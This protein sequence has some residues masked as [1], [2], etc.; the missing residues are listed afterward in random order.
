MSTA[1]KNK[2]ARQP[3]FVTTG[4]GAPIAITFGMTLLT[5]GLAF[6]LSKMTAG[7]SYVLRELSLFMDGLAGNMWLCVP[8]LLC[9]GGAKLLVSA[10]HRVSARH[11]FLVLCILLLL[12][13]GYTLI[14]KVPMDGS[15]VSYMDYLAR[16]RD[17]RDPYADNPYYVY[18]QQAFRLGR[19]GAGGLL[20]M[21][22]A[23]PVWKL[24]RNVLGTVLLTILLIVLLMALFRFN[25]GRLMQSASAKKIKRPNEKKPAVPVAASVMNEGTAFPAAEPVQPQYPF[26]QQADPQPAPKDGFYSAQPNLYEEYFSTRPAD[27]PYTAAVPGGDTQSAE[28]P[29]PQEAPAEQPDSDTVKE[30]GKDK[31]NVKSIFQKGKAAL[32]EKNG[33]HTGETANDDLPWD[34]APVSKEQGRTPAQIQT[35]AGSGDGSYPLE[36]PRQ[37][38]WSEQVRMKQAEA[39]VGKSPRSKASASTVAKPVYTDPAVPITGKRIA[40]NHRDTE[41]KADEKM[42]GTLAPKPKQAKNGSPALYQAPPMQLLDPPKIVRQADYAQEDQIRAGIILNTLNS[43]NVKAEIRQVTHGP[44]ITRFAFQIAKGIRVKQVTS[45][46]ENVALELKI[47]DVRMEAPIPGTNYVGIEAPNAVIDPVTLREVLESPQM[48]NSAHPLLV[49]LGKDVAGTPILC[50]LS[51]MPHLLIAGATNSGKSVCIHSIVC[52]LIMHSTPAQVRLIMIDP[53]QVELLLYKDIPHLLIPVISDPRKAAGALAWVVQEMDERYRKFS[54]AEANNI[55]IYNEINAGTEEVLPYI[56]VIID[57][58]ADLMQVCRK[59][60]EASIS[61]MAALA[62][63]AG[64]YMVVATQRPSVDVITGVVKNNIPSRIA[65]AVSSGNDSRTIIDR[66]GAEKL[67]GKGDMLYKPMDKQMPTRVQGCLITNKEIKELTG[68]IRSHYDSDYDPDISEEIEQMEKAKR[69]RSEPDE[70][71]GEGGDA[72]INGVDEKLAEAIEMAIED[73]QT[74]TSM[75]Q[76]RLGVGYARAGRLV[77]EMERRGIIS[78]SEGSKPRKTLMTQEEYYRDLADLKMNGE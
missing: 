73:G 23:Y 41:E 74:S 39:E 33:D 21:L 72:D 61:R 34:D 38:S 49:A 56:V 32:S 30:S 37:I 1:V 59:D 31:W 35:A 60:V 10:R 36:Q 28:R 45:T 27:I 55:E 42:D 54:E 18:M 77:D 4:K 47:R 75:L 53:K 26:P 12:M 62:R 64:I 6:L 16:M 71:G 17:E 40:I 11:F 50:D 19:N 2:K 9:W 7:E 51:K 65:F 69:G 63:A 48:Q 66:Y 29:R 13:A 57:E 24:F 20:G 15:S 76:R 67:I 5:L 44:S 3:A 70:I 52:S 58:M 78:H 8:F 14:A 22:I 46:L 25:P 68:Y 43:F